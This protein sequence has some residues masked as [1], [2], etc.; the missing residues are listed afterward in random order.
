MTNDKR[1]AES[2]FNQQA[3]KE[4]VGRMKPELVAASEAAHKAKD[5]EA[6]GA[7]EGYSDFDRSVELGFLVESVVGLCGPHLRLLNEIADALDALY[8]LEEKGL[9]EPETPHQH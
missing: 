3:V 5:V 1:K 6:E 7:D 8:E 2:R 4:A 9:H